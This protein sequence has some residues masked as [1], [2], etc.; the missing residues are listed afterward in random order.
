LP[1]VDAGAGWAGFTQ[2]AST[3]VAERYHDLEVI[4]RL[5]GELPTDRHPNA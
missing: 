3:L 5:R 4:L 2:A 1:A